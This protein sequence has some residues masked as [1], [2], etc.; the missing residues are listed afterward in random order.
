M[1]ARTEHGHTEQDALRLQHGSDVLHGL[2]LSLRGTREAV[3]DEV[4]GGRREPSFERER[5]EDVGLDRGEVELRE[6]GV[7]VG[8]NV[9]VRVK[10]GH[11]APGREPG[12]EDERAGSWPHV[13]VPRSDV[14]SVVVDDAVSRDSP[15]ETGDRP[16]D[17]RVVQ[18]EEKGGVL[19]LPLPCW[20]ATIQGRT[21]VTVNAFPGRNDDERLSRP[22]M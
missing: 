16:E 15:H 18:P 17:N 7:A 1:A 20:V 9:R 21:S 12:A 4:E 14:A 19:R 10:D 3:D 22:P 5:L 11:L 13:E 6:A 2:R 8:E